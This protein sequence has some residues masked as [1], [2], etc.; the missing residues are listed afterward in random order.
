MSSSFRSLDWRAIFPRYHQRRDPGRHHR[1]A[2]HFW[3]EDR[4]I[5]KLYPTSVPLTEEL[6]RRGRTE[7]IEKVVNPPWRATPASWSATR[8][9]PS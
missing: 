9:G 8:N 5:Y 4:T 2:L 6:T 3:S 7:V 1:R